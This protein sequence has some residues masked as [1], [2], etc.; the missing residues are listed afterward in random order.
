ME[1][2]E[3]KIGTLQFFLDRFSSRL[4]WQYLLTFI[5]FRSSK[6][7]LKDMKMLQILFKKWL[8]A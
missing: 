4:E 5:I 1:G 7:I 8:L 3:R 2:S 6:T